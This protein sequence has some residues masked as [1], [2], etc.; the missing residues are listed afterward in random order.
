GSS[1][2]RGAR[3][4]RLRGRGSL[5]V[6]GRLPRPLLREAPLP[7]RAARAGRPQQ[8]PRAGTRGRRARCSP[9]TALPR[10]R[11]DRLTVAIATRAGTVEILERALAGERLSDRDA[12]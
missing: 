8:V 1:R 12:L 7:L 9:R 5:R 2:P 11:S 3:A 10:R 4:A 6:P